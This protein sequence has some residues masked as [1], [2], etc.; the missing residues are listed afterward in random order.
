MVMRFKSRGRF[1]N[2]P[3]VGLFVEDD[4]EAFGAVDADGHCL[5]DV[6][7]FAGAAD[8]GGVAG[9]GGVTGGCPGEEIA[10]E[11]AGGQQ[12]DV[13]GRQQCCQAAF[14]GATA[15]DD[16]TGFCQPHIAAADANIGGNAKLAQITRGL[17]D[18]MPGNIGE[19]GG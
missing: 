1:A 5:F 4:D 8:E 3:E 7:R 18:E 12:D 17:A 19:D 9:R 11:F 15:N 16:G 6:G 2:R 10:G 13:D 14:A